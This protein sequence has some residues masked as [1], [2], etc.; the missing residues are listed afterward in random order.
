MF[1]CFRPTPAVLDISGFATIPETPRRPPT[2]V[3][4]SRHVLRRPPLEGEYVSVTDSSGSRVYLKQTE[5]AGSK[6]KPCWMMLKHFEQH[7]FLNPDSLST[8]IHTSG[9]QCLYTVCYTVL[10]Y[11]NFFAFTGVSSGSGLEVGTKL[12]WFTG[13]AVSA[14]RCVERST[15]REGEWPGRCCLCIICQIACTGTHCW[16]FRNH[17]CEK[18]NHCP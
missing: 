8:C 2:A 15:G 16:F 1:V 5:E 13:A 4:A 7:L 18:Y 9:V 10:L 12:P 14:N 17:T 3:S 11:I 6:V